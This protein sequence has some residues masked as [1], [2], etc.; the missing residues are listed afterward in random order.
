MVKRTVLSVAGDQLPAHLPDTGLI[1][2]VERISTRP[3]LSPLI[4]TD[5]GH[6]FGKSCVLTTEVE[7]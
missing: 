7:F 4:G 6:D 2:P 5:G 3:A 1:Y